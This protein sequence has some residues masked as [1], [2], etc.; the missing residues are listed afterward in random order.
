MGKGVLIVKRNISF[1]ILQYCKSDRFIG[2]YFYG[3]S[4]RY[5]KYNGFPQKHARYLQMQYRMKHTINIDH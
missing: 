5:I 3:T 1:Q 4:T 2:E